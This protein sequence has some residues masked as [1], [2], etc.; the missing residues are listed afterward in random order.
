MASADT[1]CGIDGNQHG[2]IKRRGKKY[3]PE[4]DDIR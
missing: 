4:E 2:Y 3:R 1:S